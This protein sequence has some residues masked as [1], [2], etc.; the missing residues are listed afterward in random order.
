MTH[1]LSRWRASIIAHG[2]LIIIHGSLLLV[3]L[4][5]VAPLLQAAPLCT[6]DGA[7]HLFRTVA[8]DRAIGDGLLYPRWFPDLAYGY[9][10]PFFNYREPLGYYAIE[11]AHLLGASFPLALNLV[12]ALGVL[13]SGQT[14]LLWV[15]DI[16]DRP[17][18]FI[19]GLVYMA[20]PYTL[21]GA[22]ARANQPEVIAL[23]LLPLILWAF[24]RLM[25]LGRRRDFALAVLSYAALLLT[26]NISSLIFTPMLGAYCV[27]RIVYGGSRAPRSASSVPHGSRLHPSSFIPHPSS[28]RL[29]LLA[30][31]LSLALTAFFWLPALAEGN[32]V[33]LYLTHAT[34]GNDYHFNFLS[35]GELLGG[36]GVS[37]PALLNPPRRIILGWP[38]LALAVLGLLLNLKSQIL[39]L[40]SQR[41]HVIA[42]AMLLIGLV[43]MALPIT[44]PLWDTLPLI[45]FAQFPWRFVGRALLP[46]ALLAGAFAYHAPCLTFGHSQLNHRRRA[47]LSISLSLLLSIAVLICAAPQLYPRVCAAPANLSI[48]E[49]FNYE[50]ATGHIGVDPLGAYLPVTVKARPTASPLEAQYAQGEIVTRFDRSALPA[51]ATVIAETYR[52]NFAAIE[53]DTPIGFRATY[54][55]FD[56]PGWRATIDDQPAPLAPSDPTGLI[57]F[58]VPAG[59]HRLEVAFGVTP[60]RAVADVIS[61][62]GLLALALTLHRL[63]PAG[64]R[65]RL[66]P[67]SFILPPSS[68]HLPP[69]TFLLVP[70][71]FLI[72]KVALIDPQLTPLRQTQL[73]DDRL[74]GVRSST[75]IDFGERLRLL[76]YAVT[77]DTAPSGETVRVDLY[78]RA[79]QPLD[80]NYQTTVGLVDE[81]GEIWSPKTLERPRDYQ[82]Y[83]ATT[84]WPTDAYAVDSFELPIRPGT[85]PGRYSIYVEVF[86]RDTLSPL[87]ANSFAPQPASRPFAANLAPLDV[88]PA[89]RTFTAAELGIYNFGFD[90]PATPDLTLIGLNLDRSDARP[91][92]AV[93]LTLFW[94][95]TRAMTP[96]ADL[97]I[98][99]IDD[100][101]RIVS[102]DRARLSSATPASAQFIQLRRERIPPR[103]VTGVYRWRG[104]ING[105]VIFEVGELRVTAPDRTFVEPAIEHRLDQTFEGRIT[106][107]GYDGADCEAR[108]TEC[109][110]TLVWRAE[111]ELAVSYKV[112][113][114]LLDAA[115][116]PRAQV[117]ALP[118][119]GTRPTTGWL[120]GEIITDAYTLKLP[121]DFQPAL[122]YRLVTGLYQELHNTRLKLPNGNDF[123]ELTTL[124]KKG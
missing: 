43:F 82:D 73:Q 25:I 92:D 27:G 9:G 63:K 38:Q 87:P 94:Q 68:F 42:A 33:Q 16:F 53:L 98:Q 8:L 58:D 76:G 15:S 101:Q 56:F 77:P 123:V 11:A 48:T 90:Q 3:G 113:V 20:A 10:F 102:E 7:L 4:I 55:T 116:V 24:R 85:P 6:D 44:Q 107:V 119:D 115:G 51:G 69:S 122:P 80:T 67:S 31:L 34:R 1:L 124:K 35:V 50:R 18:G 110:I 111:Q 57:T 52:P 121:P 61:L 91:G 30:L 45:R 2:S 19:A 81:A 62:L 46:A 17:A 83:P 49:V 89:E 103:A 105:Q 99:L 71:I 36:P 112:F 29:A 93:L 72:I 22:I 39:N 104:S 120:P 84:T 26:H 109:S 41:A 88:T 75:P 106:L 54:L 32:A 23:A 97:T 37:D 14:M 117:D 65:F 64:D 86:A 13:L 21:I 95:T 74:S 70:V 108:N 78:W 59:R 114:Q 118:V 79:L 60:I 100:Q 66:H 28:L 12:L 40:K 5:L 47:S 96:F